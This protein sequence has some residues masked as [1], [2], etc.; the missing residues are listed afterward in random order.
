MSKSFRLDPIGD[1]YIWY[2]KM[3]IF[4]VKSKFFKW[5]HAF[6][7]IMNMNLA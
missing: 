3:D 5:A 7:N 1:V 4:D 2:N 6:Y